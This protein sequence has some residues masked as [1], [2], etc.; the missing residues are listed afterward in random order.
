MALTI[1]IATQKGNFT[2]KSSKLINSPKTTVFSY[3]ND[4][5]NWQKFSSWIDSD[6]AMKLSYSPITSGSQSSLTWE[7]SNDN[8][9]IETLYTKGND[10][11]V[12]KMEFN[13][14]ASEVFWAFK[15]TVG[16][17][18]V[19][20][21]SVGKMNFTQKI[22][23]FF[24]GKPQNS[25]AEVYDKCLANLDKS[26]NFENTIFDVKINGIVKKLET[27][28]LRQSFTSKI[29]DITRNANVVFG[30]IKT[31]CNQNNI[32]QNGRPFI[33]YHT[34]DTIKDLTRVSF[35][36]PIKEQIFTSQGSD[37][38]SGKLVAF[39][40]LK[41]T[42]TGNYTYKN[43]A[44]EKTLEYTA[45]KKILTGTTFSHLEIFTIGKN[46]SLNPSKWQT[47]IY[48]PIAPKVIPTP[49][50]KVVKDSTVIAPA[51]AVNKSQE[52]SEF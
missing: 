37:I 4:Y 10:S 13:G 1:Y 8:G 9:Y 16:G 52:E 6:K 36:I 2:V 41:T 28:Y 17:T 3:V 7:G 29:S 19:T 18:K 11:I 34:Y 26:L 40:A 49:Y 47:D 48:F 12:Q 33:I 27:F 23:A 43:K 32:S 21:K 46:E 14:T 31:F 45:S 38:L 25:L 35:C 5:K 30:K 51:P 42:L 22:N 50:K 39:E 24:N 44:L 15:D 20:W